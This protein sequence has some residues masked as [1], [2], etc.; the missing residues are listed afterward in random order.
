MR[1]GE[2]KPLIERLEDLDKKRQA[3]IVEKCHPAT[4]EMAQL[5]KDSI[6]ARKAM[7]PN[8]PHELI[9]G[10]EDR[11]E[12]RLTE[13]HLKYSGPVQPEPDR[14]A[15]QMIF[16]DAALKSESDAQG[17]A[18][19]I[20]FQRHKTPAK[21]DAEKMRAKDWKASRRI[22]R[23]IA[24]L[25]QLRCGQGPIE[26][27]KGNEEHWNMFETLWGMGLEKLTP[28]EL[29][30][31]FD[32]YCPCDSKAHEPDALKN[33]RARFRKALFPTAPQA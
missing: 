6:E 5:W 14:F 28:E 2:P 13:I 18:E 7:G 29:T 10:I 4:F 26:P 3:A 22:Q 11:V 16:S 27:F 25:E 21:R 17:V 23:T 31:F 1:R 20:H 8:P 30:V 24:D 15:A 9:A 33:L 12:K 19:A 32:K